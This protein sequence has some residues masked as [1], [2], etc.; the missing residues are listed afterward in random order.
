M[1]RRSANRGIL[2]L[3]SPWELDDTDSNRSTVLPFIE[4]IAKMA[5]DTDV[6]HANFY[7]ENSFKKAL[8]CLCKVRY[9]ST[10]V[11][12]AAHGYEKNIGDVPIHKVL[13][14]VTSLSKKYNITGIVF[15][16]CFVGENVS[17]IE[18]WLEESN[19]LWA[20]GYSS[21]SFW[22]EG[23]LIDCSLISKM[24]QLSEEDISSLKRECLVEAFS[25]ALKVF[26]LNMVIGHD[27]DEGEV[28]LRDSLKIIAQ[29]RGRGYRAKDISQKIF[30]EID[31]LS[32]S[33]D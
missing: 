13:A 16:S 19:I 3:E 15:G 14:A 17:A 2:V 20:A 4:G 33:D 25:D 31:S 28:I 26:N 1:V 8:E 24:L 30:D 18:V 22:F 10:V 32:G 7:E 5:G 9:E 11:Y 6:A 27:Y 23:T 21:S 12:I 29:P